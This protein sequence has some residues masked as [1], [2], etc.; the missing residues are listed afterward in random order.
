MKAESG[1]RKYKAVN[2]KWLWMFRACCGAQNV[3]SVRQ[4]KDI[5]R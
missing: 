4:W 1:N 3:V 5:L 2:T